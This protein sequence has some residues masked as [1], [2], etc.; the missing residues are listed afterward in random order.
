MTVRLLQTY[1]R[2]ESRDD[3]PMVEDLG[4]SLG[5]KYGVRLGF[6]TE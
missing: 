3:R 4:A 6:Y 2:F 1:K 5:S